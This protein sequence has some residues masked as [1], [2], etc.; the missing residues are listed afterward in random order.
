MLIVWLAAGF[1]PVACQS[2]EVT[3]TPEPL[4]TFL[5]N[6]R[7]LAADQ[8][9]N[10]AVRVLE[11][12]A[13]SYPTS[14][15]PLIQ[16]GQI[17]LQQQQLLPAEDAFNRALARDLQNSLATAGLAETYLRQSN[18]LRSLSLWKEAA[19]LDP[20]LPG[21]FSGLGRVYLARLEFDAAREAFLEQLTYHPDDEAT[22]FL[23]ALSAPVDNKAARDYLA[24]L[25]ADISESLAA[26]RDYL[27][28]TLDSVKNRSPKERSQAI[29]I[30]MVQIEAWPL[31]I[32]ALQIAAA[33]DTASDAEKAETLAFLG[34]ALAQYGRPALV[35]F[36]QAE[37]LDA[38]SPLPA[39]FQ[40]IYLRQQHAYGVA[41]DMLLH[42]AALDEKN[43]AVYIELA[44]LKTEQG[45][46]SAAEEYY[47]KAVEV[48]PDDVDLQLVQANFY[49]GRSYR[50]EEA[51]IPL[52]EALVE[53]DDKNAEA[54]DLLGWMQFLT[55]D[56]DEAETNLRRAIELDPQLMRARFH[57]ARFLEAQGQL[58]DA[59]Q[60]YQTITE[61]DVTGAYRAS[62]WEGIYRIEGQ[63]DE[64]E[65]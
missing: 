46:L 29:S 61:R 5:E 8:Q 42:A 64:T 6:A 59:H 47:M 31:A 44:K 53:I 39:Y 32:Y 2:G 40:G 49:A 14:A 36:R 37:S 33:D 57:L 17:Y 52:A 10:E 16:V 51:G 25:P 22:W 35:T 65:K 11:Q 9:Y 58:T 27:A 24:K 48:A 41:E 18:T 30:A 34:H 19:T 4:A 1:G 20:E 38:S 60:A 21:V 23:A 54:Y 7:D 26:Q 55:G 3:P 62:A 12:A 28:A 56:L 50:L 15:R 43:P 45:F 63:L 13:D